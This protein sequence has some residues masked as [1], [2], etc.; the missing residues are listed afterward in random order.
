MA[1]KL[2]NIFDQYD[3]KENHL[4]HSLLHVLNENRKLLKKILHTYGI[5]LT[6]KQINLLTQV[7]P[8]TVKEKTSVPDGYIYTKDYKLMGSNLDP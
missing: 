3:Q 4:T 2:R 7:A 8:R 6:S 5:R 1:K